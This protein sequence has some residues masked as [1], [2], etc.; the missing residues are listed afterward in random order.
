MEIGYC[1]R[2][3]YRHLNKIKQ[4]WVSYS[5]AGCERKL[6]WW[7]R[8]GWEWIVMPV[9]NDNVI[10]SLSGLALIDSSWPSVQAYFRWYFSLPMDWPDL[11]SGFKW[12]MLMIGWGSNHTARSHPKASSNW[13]FW[14]C[15][16]I[17]VGSNALQKQY[18]T[19]TYYFLL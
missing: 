5:C 2:H 9:D 14:P 17:S 12:G 4:Q 18:I 10:M 8:W 13:S 3:A 11:H 19:V 6:S 7:W 1:L 15:V 16:S